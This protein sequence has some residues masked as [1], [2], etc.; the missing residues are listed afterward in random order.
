MTVKYFTD[1]FDYLQFNNNFIPFETIFSKP[2]RP[3]R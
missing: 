2:Y 1:Y 3:L